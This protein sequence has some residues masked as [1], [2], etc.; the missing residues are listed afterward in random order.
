MCA[1]I[2]YIIIAYIYREKYACYTHTHIYIK[3]YSLSSF[4]LTAQPAPPRRRL[5]TPSSTADIEDEALGTE[6]EKARKCPT[7]ARMGERALRAPVRAT[8]IPCRNTEE[9]IFVVRCVKRKQHTNSFSLLCLHHGLQS[10]IQLTGFLY[11][12]ML[13]KHFMLS[14]RRCNRFRT[15]N[16]YKLTFLFLFLFFLDRNQDKKKK[17][18]QHQNERDLRYGG[19]EQSGWTRI[20]ESAKPQHRRA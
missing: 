9:A 7:V 2:I 20:D 6:E 4:Q 8:A 14:S 16:N 12:V 13:N 18:F 19:W 15:A 3:V 5:V 11:C 17:T 1:D 10:R